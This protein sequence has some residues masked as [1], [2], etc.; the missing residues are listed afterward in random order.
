MAG[1]D[2]GGYLFTQRSLGPLFSADG[3]ARA[4]SAGNAAL[5]RLRRVR[6]SKGDK[7]ERPS[8]ISGEAAQVRGLAVDLFPAV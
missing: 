4:P 6:R 2:S 3:A 7:F 1:I 8:L 5:L